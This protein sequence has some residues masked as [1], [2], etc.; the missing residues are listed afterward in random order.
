VAA[1]RQ[2]A[3]EAQYYQFFHINKRFF[4]GAKNDNDQYQI[5]G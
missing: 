3:D 2:K 1:G 5:A 4:A